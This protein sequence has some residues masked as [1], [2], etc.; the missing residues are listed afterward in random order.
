MQIITVSAVLFQRSDGHVLTVRK[1]STTM[2]MLPGGKPESGESAADCARREVA[3]ELGIELSPDDIEPFGVW[4]AAAANE[5]GAIVRASVFR[6]A[7][8][9][10]AA[11]EPRAQAEIAEVRWIDPAG[12]IDDEQEAPLNRE[13][14]FPQLLRSVGDGS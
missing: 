11:I 12:G 13:L 10:A 3:E 7:A 4:D 2:F 1:R 14:V 9:V 6:A 5:A 8:S